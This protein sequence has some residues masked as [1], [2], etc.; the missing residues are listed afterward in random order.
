MRNKKIPNM[1]SFQIKKPKTLK[2]DIFV[3]NFHLELIIFPKVYS[4][5]SEMFEIFLQIF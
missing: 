5:N 1:L 2:P 3:M 4:Y